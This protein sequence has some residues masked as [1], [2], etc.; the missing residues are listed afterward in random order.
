MGSGASTDSVQWAQKVTRDEYERYVKQLGDG[1]DE[2][3]G[4]DLEELD[5]ASLAMRFELMYKACTREKDKV[6]QESME[7]HPVSWAAKYKGMTAGEQDEYCKAVV[8]AQVQLDKATFKPK[9]AEADYSKS[10]SGSAADTKAE[11]EA[12]ALM[13][14][15][16]G[17]GEEEKKEEG[18][19]LLSPPLV[20]YNKY[21]GKPD[22]IRR[23]D[24]LMLL[25]VAPWCKW[26]SQSG[27][28]MYIQVATKEIASI[29]PNNY[30]ESEDRGGGILTEEELNGIDTGAVSTKPSGDVIPDGVIVCSMADLPS[31][32]DEVVDKKKMTPL[33]LDPSEERKVKTFFDYKYRVADA[34]PLCIPFAKS[35]LK[36]QDCL[37]TYRKIL[38]GALR[39]GT[40]FALYLGE[41]THDEANFKKKMCKK[42]CFPM[43]CMVE[44]GKKLLSPPF[45]PRYKKI[46]RAEDIDEN[47]GDTLKC[48]DGFR[49]VVISA[50]KPSEY[51][52]KLADSLALGYMQ[53]I[54]VI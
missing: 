43:E 37:E 33:I 34:S 19:P 20:N 14:G 48:P 50:L 54:Y 29:R 5:E 36:R 13:K 28:Y 38:V 1:T 23:Y 41:L 52:S 24:R 42:D 17:E 40:T 2:E 7:L 35:G 8:E 15:D 39:A 4:Y 18:S 21:I 44:A 49:S 47:E 26:F 46:L 3:L 45:D 6:L 51:E 32:I 27:C 31:I 30:E 16:G 9:A 11:K 10:F 22:L 12:A 25:R 53:V